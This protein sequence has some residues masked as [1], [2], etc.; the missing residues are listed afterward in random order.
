MNAITVILATRNA[1]TFITEALASVATQTIAPREILVVDADST[2]GTQELVL[3]MPNTQLQRQTGQGLWQAWN[4]AIGQISTPFIAIIDSDDFWEPNALE[5]HMAAFRHNPAAVVSIG[6]TRFFS[7]SE[8]LPAGI[9]PDILNGSHRGAVPGATLF[10]KE[11]FDT[12]GLFREDLTTASDIDWFLR[13]RQSDLAVAEPAEVVLAKRIHPDN[14]GG[15]FARQQ[16]YDQD[17]IRIARESIQRKT[18][19][20]DG[21]NQ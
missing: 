1:A 11:V 21:G 12:L 15:V 7:N 9:R 20:T 5:V 14:L 18:K 8:A 16:Q 19:A 17:L 2:D 13:L 4:Q 6:R 3:R 10:R